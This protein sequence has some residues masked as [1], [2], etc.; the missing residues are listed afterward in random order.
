MKGNGNILCVGN[1]LRLRPSSTHVTVAG[2][3]S[4]MHNLIW[5]MVLKQC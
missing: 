5:K 2:F 3:L 1:F 4:G